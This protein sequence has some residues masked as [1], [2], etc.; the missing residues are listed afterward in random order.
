MSDISDAQHIDD[1]KLEVGY[2]PAISDLVDQIRRNL[3]DWLGYVEKEPSL[4][5]LRARSGEIMEAIQMAS[6]L[7]GA[8]ELAAQLAM[9]VDSKFERLGLGRAWYPRLMS[10]YASVTDQTDG[11]PQAQ[12]FQCLMNYYLY[13]GDL[14]RANMVINMLLDVA[15]TD[16]NIPLQE[17]M[18]GA[19]TVAAV[20]TTDGEGV[21]LAEQLLDL[22]QLTGNKHL[23]GKTL[24][25]LCQYYVNQFDPYRTFE[26][27]QMAY[28]VGLGLSEDNFVI[29]GLHHMAIG[30]Q[31]SGQASRAF[32]YLEKAMTHSQVSGDISHM[33][34]LKYT[35]GYGC[36]LIADYEQA[37]DYLAGA[38]RVFA[39]R[40]SYYASA[41]YM[42]GLSLMQL[43]RLSEAEEM[44]KQAISEWS[45]IKRT[46]EPYYAQHALA[47][48]YWKGG[49]FDEAVRQAEQTLKELEAVDNLRRKGLEDELRKDLDKYRSSQDMLH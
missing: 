46:F 7:D 16:P 31:L 25:A 33:S 42:L 23:M 44:L 1:S 24:G 13:H 10:L 14:L 34:Y 29:N 6:G 12:L 15:E 11:L 26:Y 36:Y 20:L 40:G 43:E 27:G 8:A 5:E 35:W 28:C 4:S 39:G 45:N 21:V 3:S 32:H 19:A 41:L 2:A 48:V 22:A 37:A 47:H 18:V 30:L 9:A 49:R 17:T 38:I